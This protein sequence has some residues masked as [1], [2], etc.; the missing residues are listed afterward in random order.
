LYSADYHSSRLAPSKWDGGVFFFNFG[1]FTLKDCQDFHQAKDGD[2]WVEQSS[3]PFL[4]GLLQKV[5]A[6]GQ[7][8]VCGKGQYKI[9]L[10]VIY[11]EM[12]ILFSILEYDLAFSHKIIFNR[13]M[14]PLHMFVQI[15]RYMMPLTGI[16][17]R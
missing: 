14:F 16:F 15:A 2:G 7:N 12:I 1:L 3:Q 13:L 5:C 17:V 4:F 9:L 6:I 10:Y 11:I 8:F